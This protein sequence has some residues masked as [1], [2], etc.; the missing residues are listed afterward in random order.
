M[1]KDFRLLLQESLIQKCQLNPSYSLRA[2]ARSLGIASSALSSI[3][4]GK[5]PITEKMKVRLGMALGLSAT[6]IET[7]QR[8][9]YEPKVS[10]K[11]TIQ[12]RQIALDTFAVIS[13]W[14]HYAILELTQVKG[15][16][17]NPDYISKKLGVTKSEIN[18]AIERLKRLGFLTEVN[19]KWTDTTPNN[20]FITSVNDKKTSM[21]SKKMQ[22]QILEKSIEAL[23]KVSPDKRSHTSITM[24]IDTAD[25]LKAFEIIKN[26]RRNLNQNMDSASVKTNVYQLHIG[27]FPVEKEEERR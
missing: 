10:N 9:E 8:G 18:F 25:L 5:R 21:A 6:D 22:K 3:L 26:F 7:L 15:F 13:D 12:F 2:Y 27:F 20:G 19:G 24:A 23:E 16:Q 4:N 17:S 14:H 11:K 1:N